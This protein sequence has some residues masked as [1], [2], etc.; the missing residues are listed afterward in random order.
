MNSNY[1]VFNGKEY[2]K[3]NGFLNLISSTYNF[4]DPIHMLINFRLKKIRKIKKHLSEYT[5]LVCGLFNQAL[6]QSNL[7]SPIFD[8]PE[9]LSGE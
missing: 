4:Y 7:V 1:I 9:N 8:N 2:F 6:V 5:C 3:K